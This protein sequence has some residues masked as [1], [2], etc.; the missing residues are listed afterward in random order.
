MNAAL[1]VPV[2]VKLMNLTTSVLVMGLVLGCV[3]A[4]L[5]WVLRNP[6]FAIKEIAVVGDTAHN[7][8]ATLRAKVAPRLEGNFFTLDLSNARAAFQSAPWV[9]RAVVK[10]EFPNRLHVWL[11]EHVPA[12]R[13]GDDDAQ[14]LNNFGEVFDAEGDNPDDDQLPILH[15]P[16]G[17]AAQVLAMH[18]VLNP[19]VAPLRARVVE[20]EL[21][22][23]GNWRA[24]LD[25]GAVIE[26]GRGSP[27][28]LAARLRQFVGTVLEVAGRHQRQMDAI[29]SVDLRH[30]S[31][32]AM[33]LRGVTTVR[34]EA[35]SGKAVQR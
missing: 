24:E 34:A 26:L 12:A 25:H 2:D 23:R 29:E 21:L 18:R 10:R 19:L 33:T 32:Y 20:L 27:Q 4:G 13:W 22:G 1:P 3:A 28:E 30:A 9:R 17:Q 7:S 11:E 8:A 16:E 15:G 35:T 14:L 6:A 31:G 5:W